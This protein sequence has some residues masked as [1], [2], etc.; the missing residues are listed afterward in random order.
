MLTPRPTTKK[1]PIWRGDSHLWYWRGFHSLRLPRDEWPTSVLL[2]VLGN[3]TRPDGVTAHPPR[4][5]SVD[6]TQYESEVVYSRGGVQVVLADLPDVRK[7][8]NAGE[9][10]HKHTSHGTMEDCLLDDARHLVI[11]CCVSKIN[12]RLRS[13]GNL[14]KQKIYYAAGKVKPQR[15]VNLPS[16]GE[17][18]QHSFDFTHN[19]PSPITF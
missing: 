1:S 15:F 17:A 13:P 4:K 14:G 2:M 7:D 16:P 18:L 12:I 11:R 5:S 10:G 19:S 8:R 6:E 9:C 3:S